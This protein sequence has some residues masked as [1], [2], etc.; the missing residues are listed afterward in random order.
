MDKKEMNTF[1]LGISLKVNVRERLEIELSYFE[2][3]VQHLSH[4]AGETLEVEKE[5]EK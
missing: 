5:K 1:L 4:F 2:V 3:A